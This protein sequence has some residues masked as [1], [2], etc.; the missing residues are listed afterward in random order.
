MSINLWDY[1]FWWH[2]ATGRY[3]V[4][5]KSIP[6]KDPFS[7][8]NNLEEN[9]NINPKREQLIL[10]SYWLSQVLFYKIYDA[11]SDKGIIILRSFI[12][13][14]VIFLIFFWFKRCN[15]NFYIIYP[16][17]FL[18]FSQTMRFTG[19][20]PVLFTALFSVLVFIIL[21]DFKK[22]KSKLLFFL[23]PLMLL[24]SNMHGGFILGIVF[25]LAFIVGEALN[26]FILK[27]S[28]VGKKALITLLIVGIIAIAVSAIN[29]NV[30]D[31]FLTLSKQ[32]KMY[33]THV[34]EYYSPFSLY[35]EH[36]RPID[37]EYIILLAVC[38]IVVILRN[39]KFDI[40]Y[41][42]ILCG[43]LYMSLTAIR[44]V[45]YFVCIGTMIVGRELHYILEDY[46]KKV[47][48][49][50]LKFEYVASF[51]ILISSVLFT[52]GFFDFNKVTFAKALT[53]SVPKGAADFIESHSIKGNMF[54]DMGFGGYLIWRLYPEKQ[55]FIDTRQVNYT[56]MQETG[57]ISLALLS[58]DENKRT[59]PEGKKPLW[60]RLLDHY[61]IDLIVIDTVEVFGSIRPIVFSLMKSDQ[62]I[63]VYGDLISIVFVRNSKENA[64]FIDKYRLSEDVV[65]NLII[66]RLTNLS[67][68][69]R[70]NPY[71][72]ISI[73]DV[74]YN[75]GRYKDAMQAYIYA[76]NRH[77]GKTFIK[78]KID[79]L[80]KLLENETKT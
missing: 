60:E 1:D 61:N 74:F 23:I 38:P 68:I 46:F 66:V 8:V 36:L 59:L 37:W 22:R 5:T 29:P 25:I 7:F 73:G 4:E 20:R 58:L 12:L 67:T 28:E 55:V 3:I 2:L 39:K 15:V 16:F 10:K 33:Q 50:K 65:Y 57:M 69:N 62:W 80:K 64:K 47:S 49:N 79:N 30:F 32:N 43:L 17:L 44:F 18:V 63:P 78:E 14:A 40:V 6:D 19:E 35:K 26:H 48:F 45:I 41:F 76:D 34:Q 24:W 31:A 42:L 71:Y 21:D 52:F 13:F 53:I 72:L 9:R 51:M 11:F 54:N 77:P 56:V 75:I 27:K 70:E